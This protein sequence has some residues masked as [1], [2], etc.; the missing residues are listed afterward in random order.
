MEDC[1]REIRFGRRESSSPASERFAHA[2]GKRSAKGEREVHTDCTASQWLGWLTGSSSGR[3]QQW[4]RVARAQE[5]H[6]AICTAFNDGLLSIDQAALA[7]GVHESL[8][9]TF[10]RLAASATIPQLKVLARAARRARPTGEP[11]VPEARPLSIGFDDDGRLNL[12][13]NL[14]VDES[15][16]VHD[17]LREARDAVHTVGFVVGFFAER[18]DLPEQFVEARSRNRARQRAVFREE[19]RLDGGILHPAN[20]LVEG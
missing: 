13:G 7:V 9:E 18:E 20:E 11:G 17:A 19:F 8:D 3:V 6:R 4:L 5:T 14:D 12:S 15:R 2:R 10:A 16:V 1:T